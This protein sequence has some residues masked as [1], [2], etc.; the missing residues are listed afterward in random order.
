[1]KI[2]SVTVL[3]EYQLELVFSDG[4]SG[5]VDLSGLVGDGAFQRW[6]A[7][8]E[9]D[10]VQIG[11]SGEIVWEDYADLCPD[12]LYLQVTGKAVEQ[13]FPALTSGVVNA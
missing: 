6:E 12:A 4:T 7:P 11:S 13:L 5:K 3:D 10:K 2:T 8:G 9:F 1:M